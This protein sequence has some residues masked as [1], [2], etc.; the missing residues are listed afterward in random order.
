MTRSMR[1]TP[2]TEAEFRI[3]SAVCRIWVG[4]RTHPVRSPFSFHPYSIIDTRR[5]WPNANERCRK[6]AEEMIVITSTRNIIRQKVETCSWQPLADSVVD[7]EG[8]EEACG[9]PLWTFVDWA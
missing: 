6:G 2:G 8:P 9:L 3:V 4:L 1:T 5:H 7:P